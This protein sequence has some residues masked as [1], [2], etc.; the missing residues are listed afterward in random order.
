VGFL[1]EKNSRFTNQKKHLLLSIDCCSKSVGETQK[2]MNEKEIKTFH[3]RLIVSTRDNP[4]L[5]SKKK[6]A[7]GAL[8]DS[9]KY[10]S[11]CSKD[12]LVPLFSTV[13]KNLPDYLVQENDRRLA[14]P[15]A[16]YVDRTQ[17][18][19]LLVTSVGL[20]SPDEKKP[21][22]H[23]EVE[24]FVDPKTFLEKHLL[25]PA[26]KLREKTNYALSETQ[27]AEKVG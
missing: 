21:R 15:N 17:L 1:V 26:E 24:Q 11:P 3:Y 14:D 6:K 4:I 25:P 23:Y 2:T 8:F 10:F 16:R 9:D 5:G 19:F 22:R 18:I 12:M 13:L 27:H 20:R 7:E